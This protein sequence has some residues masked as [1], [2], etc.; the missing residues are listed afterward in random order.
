MAS[1]AALTALVVVP[2]FIV[3]SEF[4]IGP[5][6]WMP[7]APAFVSNGLVPFAILIAGVAGFCILVD[8]LFAPSRNELVQAVFVLFFVAFLVLTVTGT[9]FRGAGMSL[10]W[11]WQT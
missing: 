4:A 9:W 11:P 6:G 2:A 10:E 7:G 3:I 1:V 8:K 5:G